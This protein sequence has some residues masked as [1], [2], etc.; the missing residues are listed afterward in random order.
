MKKLLALLLTIAMVM[1]LVPAAFATEGEQADAGIT[2]TYD[3]QSRWG[4]WNSNAVKFAEF[5]Y[6]SNKG[7]WEYYGN[8]KNLQ[9][10]DNSTTFN[11]NS[12]GSTMQMKSGWW[13]IKIVVP[14]SGMY[15]PKVNYTKYDN[16]DHDAFLN[17]YLIDASNPLSENT[18][19]IADNRI[20]R[21]NCT[22]DGV[23]PAVSANTTLDPLPIDAG[24][25]YLVY[26]SEASGGAWVY[27]GNLTLDGNGTE[28]VLSGIVTPSKVAVVKGEETKLSP[29]LYMNDKSEAT[30][31]YEITYSS[32]KEDVAEIDANGVIKGNIEGKATVTASAVNEAGYTV[33]SEIDVSVIDEVKVFYNVN[34]DMNKVGMKWYNQTTDAYANRPVLEAL[35]YTATNGF[36]KYHSTDPRRVLENGQ[37]DDNYIKYASINNTNAMQ[38]RAGTWFSIEIEVPVAGIYNLVM[39]NHET[40]ST[41]Y[42][43]TTNV[44]VSE[45]SNTDSANLVGNYNVYNAEAGSTAVDKFIGQVEFKNPG[46]HIVTFMPEKN[47]TLINSFSLVGGTH[48][49]II[50]GGITAG[51]AKINVDEGDTTTVSASGYISSTAEAAAFTYSSDN[52]SV[53]TVDAESG[54]VT[55]VAPGKVTISATCADATVNNVLTT[56]IEVIENL[57]GVEADETV[58]VYVPQVEGGTVTVTGATADSVCNVKAGDPIK[59]S[60]VAADGYEFRYWRDNKGGYISNSDSYTFN[61]YTNTSIIAVFDNVSGEGE[62]IGVEFFDGNKAYLGFEAVTAGT[63][64]EAVNK[65]AYGLT[66][67]TFKDWSIGKDVEINSLVRAVALYN[68]V[69]D[70][71]SGISVDGAP[72][73]A[74]YDDEI[75]KT[76]TGAKAWYRD[77]KLVGYGDTY[78]YRAWSAT[79]I[80]S[81]DEA[82]EKKVPLAVLNKSGDAYMLEYDKGEYEI[83]EAGILFGNEEHKE[84]DSCYY[85]AKV[86][87]IKAHGQFTAKANAEGTAA[88]Q[89]TV[90]G[91]VL[92]KDKNNNLMVVYAE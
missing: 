46:K 75:T 58:Q 59:V 10:I 62:I 84:V 42:D 7:L 83:I 54:L 32:D 13:A 47:Y 63:K 57:P 67:F 43:T 12:G 80:K 81:S 2:I 55:P 73:S 33:K 5:T 25:Y 4:I 34:A 35:D 28:T 20:G 76:V 87:N 29:V 65:P 69:G 85:K 50:S 38:I 77:D 60:A 88:M 1:S 18:D 37:N 30:G 72:Q 39:H 86:K 14:K 70:E 8:K 91:Y 21:I 66:G 92:Y 40:K 24:E 78:T 89:S 31:M 6:E 16:Y 53:A 51:A 74:N 90:R 71:V 64:F 56:E 45:T 11:W 36:Y 82:P 49:A 9:S 27:I 23:S 3:V 52:T 15:T 79:V 48:N 68:D 44:Y 22:E 61:P 17:L 19:L 26:E 41:S